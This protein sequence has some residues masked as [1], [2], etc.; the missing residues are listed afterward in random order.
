MTRFRK[1][2]TAFVSYSHKDAP[3]CKEFLKHLKPLIDD[4]IIATAWHDGKLTAGTM[5]DR[6]IRRQMEQAHLFIALTSADFNASGYIEGV[7]MKRAEERNQAGECRFIPILLKSWRLPERLKKYQFLPNATNAIASDRNRDEAW[8]RVVN[9]VEKAV[10]EMLKDKW[11]KAGRSQRASGSTNLGRNLPYLC[12]WRGPIG[13]I[14]SAL[15]ARDGEPRRPA[16]VILIATPDDAPKRFAD[17]VATRELAKSLALES[18]KLDPEVKVFDWVPAF[19]HEIHDKL[20]GEELPLDKKLREGLT[21][22]YTTEIGDAWSTA[23]EELL[24]RFLQYWRDWG[25][26]PGLRGLV[27]FVALIRSTRDKDFVQRIEALA[28]RESNDGV[29][30]VVVEV[31]PV[32]CNHAVNW[33]T[34]PEV[35]KR[36]RADAQEDLCEDIQRLFPNISEPLS[37]SDL[38][39]KLLQLLEKYSEEGP[40]HGLVR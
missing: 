18:V 23:K 2:L 10:D 24:T 20:G 28:A 14:H 6:T 30:M 38:A 29:R 35:K 22:L 40:P 33:P 37:M 32:T 16:V 21:V 15:Q 8:V 9:D 26:L 1:P 12:N 5:W 31:P 13:Q 25:P 27:S 36:Y 34:D 7:E 17:R 3:L 19:H 4:G 11:P 39:P